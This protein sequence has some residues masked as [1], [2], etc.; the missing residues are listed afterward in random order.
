MTLLRAI[1]LAILLPAAALFA[2]ACASVG[3]GDS[4]L[5][6]GASLPERGDCLVLDI[7]DA[8]DVQGRAVEGSAARLSVALRQALAA[9]GW[10]VFNTAVHDLTAGYAEANELHCSLILQAEFVLWQEAAHDWVDQPDT[11]Q[12][13]LRLYRTADR[14]LVA[15]GLDEAAGGTLLDAA[16]SAHRLLEPLAAEMLQPIFAGHELSDIPEEGP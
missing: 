13:R 3:L 8:R 12:L 2:P 9:H 1:A 11:V 7:D 16:Q 6:P 5:I 14:S 10:N 15:W 4:G